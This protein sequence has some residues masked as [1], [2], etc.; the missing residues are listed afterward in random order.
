MGPTKKF[1]HKWLLQKSL[2]LVRSAFGPAPDDD[3]LTHNSFRFEDQT[4]EKKKWANLLSDQRLASNGEIMDQA[5]TRSP[6]LRDFDRIVFSGPFRRL[7]GKTQCYPLTGNDTI[8]NRLTHSYEVASVGRSLGNLV[9]SFL[10]NKTFL[11]DGRF[12]NDIGDLVAA[13]CLAHDI[14]NPPFGHSGE[15]ALCDWWAQKQ[16]QLRDRIAG[17]ERFDDFKFFEGNANGFHIL[18]NARPADLTYA[19]LATYT[20]YPRTAAQKQ[21]PDVCYEKKN[22]IYSYDKDAFKTIFGACGLEKGDAWFRHPLAFLVEAADDICYNVIDLEDGVRLKIA[23]ED[24]AIGLL[25]ELCKGC[26]H[27]L[28]AGELWPTCGTKKEADNPHEAICVKLS[29]LRSAA[30][31]KLINVACKVWQDNYTEIRIGD[32]RASLLDHSGVLKE[33]TKFSRNNLYN[34]PSVLR[35]E[36]AGYQNLTKLMTLYVDAYLGD[37]N[38]EL[39]PVN[40]FA[41]RVF[42]LLPQE[43]QERVREVVCTVTERTVFK[44]LKAAD[45]SENQLYKLILFAGTYVCGMTDGYAVK[46]Y[47]E[48]SGS[49]LTV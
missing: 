30:I 1:R 12:A 29:E 13:A 40:T 3:H 15:K 23:Q 44:G 4:E 39:V 21:D 37:W 46:Q 8:H 32:F 48:L 33:L 17:D 43:E 14:G 42:K 49:A 45:L 36:A 16:P 18:V 19:T 34:S 7:A 47:K 31:K 11:P 28:G 9:G 35:I 10:A 27:Y 22:G 5:A 24:K 2:L 25:N 20:K 41:A 38:A 6:F 26:D